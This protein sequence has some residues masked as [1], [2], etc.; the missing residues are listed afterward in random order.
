M[1]TASALA[2]VS[3]AIPERA[4]SSSDSGA[5][6]PS[7]FDAAIDARRDVGG[8]DG[9]RGTGGDASSGG[10]GAAGRS[11][12]GGAGGSGGAAPDAGPTGGRGG[13]SGGAGGMG[14]SGGATGGAGG[15]TG[16]A[17][18]TGGTTGGSGGVRDASI[19]TGTGGGGPI[20][21]ASVDSGPTC[22]SDQKLCGSAC[23]SKTDPGYGCGATSCA[24]CSYPNAAS[25][26]SSGGACAM[27][28]CN[29][30]YADCNTDAKDGCETDLSKPATC[31]SCTKACDSSAPLCSNTNGTF[32]CVTGCTAPASTLC[33]SQCVDTQTSANHCGKC[34][35]KCTAPSAHGTVSC[36]GG[37][38]VTTC[39]ANY[40]ACG[41]ECVDTKNN[42]AHCGGCNQACS[43]SCVQG[44]CCTAGQ[45][46]CSGVC[47][48]TSSDLA[49][50][51]GCGKPCNGTCTNGTCC[52]PGLTYCSGACVDTKTSGAHCGGCGKACS[53]TCNAGSCCATGNAVCSGVCCSAG[54]ACCGASAACTSLD[55]T[56]N[57]GSCGNTCGSGEICNSSKVCEFQTW[58]A[59]QTKPAG[60]GSA[61]YQCLD[62]DK[63]M[64]PSNVWVPFVSGSFQIL[65]LAG[66]QVKSAPNSL[67]V[68][69]DALDENDPAEP[70]PEAHLTWTNA[71]NF[72]SK[73]SIAADVYPLET[74]GATGGGALEMLCLAFGTARTCLVRDLEIPATSF[75]PWALIFENSA[76]PPRPGWRYC[77]VAGFLDFR[78]WDHVEL[79]LAS[80]GNINIAINGVASTCSV[81]SALSGGTAVVRVGSKGKPQ[82]GNFHYDNI[83]SY[84][85]R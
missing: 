1:I 33:G 5:Q 11:G 38:C 4:P 82:V 76:L 72:I 18:G 12:S 7:S 41:T 74:H 60:V 26:C 62:F 25:T 73:V 47:S 58:C 31:G 22:P 77:E 45:S 35:T 43:K 52:A 30:N 19:D 51:G 64:P 56:T 6:D 80:D 65:S 84:I 49:N 85:Q 75:F 15:A 70:L 50:C 37:Q 29:A 10:A 61:D 53:G 9:A 78:Q 2:V 46:N 55:N 71:G 3:C 54:E 59:T 68:V 20:I 23:I 81:Q 66:D 79:S 27:G 39:A 16:G 67:H 57:C 24:P 28:S 63:G 36:T 8:S 13:S 40:T 21:D 14:G 34:D 17:G 44:L 42:L 69:T 48:D 83:V 32:Q